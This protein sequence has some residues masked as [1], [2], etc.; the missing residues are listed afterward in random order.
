MIRSIAAID[1]K[2]GI[3]KNGKIPWDLPKDKAHYRELAMAEGN[4]VLMGRRTYEAMGYLEGRH[5]YI[6]SHGDLDLSSG[7][8]LIKDI[9]KFMAEFKE[10]LWI[11]GGEAI[12]K[13]TMNYVDELYLT[14]VEADFNCDQ[15]F[16]DYS[17]FKLKNAEGPFS[18]NHLSFS[19]QLFGR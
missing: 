4:N 3:A 16:P 2:R 13:E 12:Y 10:D 18:E 9:G 8:K 19:Y 1:S 5:Y 14:I 17:S 7:C 11:I 6:V 15:F